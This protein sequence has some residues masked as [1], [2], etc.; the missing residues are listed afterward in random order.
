MARVVGR[1][2]RWRQRCSGRR[3]GR[4]RALSCANYEQTKG[5]C[6]VG[7]VQKPS[8]RG[9]QDGTVN[10]RF[11]T[12]GDAEAAAAATDDNNDDDD[13]EGEGV[14]GRSSGP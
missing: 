12:H 5:G 2:H 3:G 10:G 7:A 11:C 9:L 14:G 8:W 13:T 1:R 4:Q 6:P